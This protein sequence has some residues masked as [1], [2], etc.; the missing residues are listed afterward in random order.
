MRSFKDY[1]EDF[2]LRDG[3]PAKKI[4]GVVLNAF[5]VRLT[6]EDYNTPNLIYGFWKKSGTITKEE[7]IQYIYNSTESQFQKIREKFRWKDNK[8]YAMIQISNFVE[9]LELEFHENLAL[10]K[11]LRKVK[12]NKKTLSIGDLYEIFKNKDIAKL[13]QDGKL[14][15]IAWKTLKEKIN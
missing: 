13:V 9:D 4:N 3:T 10:Q 6:D 8:N 2:A 1:L 7:I 15:S 14:K 11:K 12:H 5:F